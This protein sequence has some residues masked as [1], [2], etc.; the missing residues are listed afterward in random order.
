MNNLHHISLKRWILALQLMFFVCYAHAVTVTYTADLSQQDQLT[1]ISRGTAYS[2]TTSPATEASFTYNGMMFYSNGAYI[3]EGNTELRVYTGKNLEITSYIGNIT[4]VVVTVTES[5]YADLTLTP[6]DDF[7]C[8]KSKSNLR[9]TFALT[10][11]AS[12]SSLSFKTNG[13]IWISKIAVTIEQPSAYSLSISQYGYSSLFHGEYDL[14]L[15]SNQSD[16]MAY[17]LLFKDGLLEPTHTFCAGDII[18]KGTPVLVKGAQ[19]TYNLAVSTATSS[20]EYE[21]VLQGL[22]V[23]GMII[24]AS[25]SGDYYYYKLTT[26]N[27]QNF[28]FY[29][30]ADDGEPFEL[31][32]AH[33]AYLRL[34][35][36]LF[37]TSEQ[38]KAFDLEEVL[39]IIT[40]T[41]REPSTPSKIFDL[42][43]R[44]VSHPVKGIYI[45]NGKK[46]LIR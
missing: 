19:G 24:D 37:T 5:K 35:K 25:N 44:Q 36:D 2:V 41:Q 12:T 6:S 16:L 26:L 23:P 43:G 8:T 15:P 13:A 4:K 46:I 31:K 7:K 20:A 28:G 18:P 45:C 38:A 1:I 17:T 14:Q 9:Y 27:Q 21:N 29:W 40:E 33:R 22:D 32:N 3:P 39:D 11:N 34:P 42:Q 30:G 10:S